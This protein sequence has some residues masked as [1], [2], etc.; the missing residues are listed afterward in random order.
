MTFN[1]PVMPFSIQTFKAGTKKFKPS[2][3]MLKYILIDVRG[4]F[5]SSFENIARGKIHSI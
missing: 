3:L 4:I 2:I 1:I 5:F